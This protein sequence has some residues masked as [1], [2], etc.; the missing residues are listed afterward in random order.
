LVFVSLALLSYSHKAV[1]MAIQEK[2]L[3]ETLTGVA[4]NI[5]ESVRATVEETVRRELS[6]AISKIMLEGDFYRQINEEI[7]SGLR[8]IYKDIS[9]ASLPA[10]GRSPEQGEKTRELFAH[11]GEQLEEVMR[12]TLEATE[13]IMGTVEKLFAMHERAGELLTRLDGPDDERREHVR[14]L[15]EFHSEL[16]D[17][18]TY[19][20]TELSFQDLTGQRLKKVV[21]A[22]GDI[23]ETAFDLY[24]SSGLMIKGKEDEPEKDLD[25]IAEQT[26]LKV[27]EIK[28]SELRGPDRNTSQGDVD[29]LL[30]S[31][32][33]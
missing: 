1:L 21:T 13:N 25:S 23:Q 7:R 10:E 30:A 33:L 18:L 2:A 31:L 22:L 14:Q 8:G 28:N 12:S 26:R 29:D 11:A 9:A 32:G 27:A 24:V 15:G 6:A 20:L 4:R 5:A 19:I 17:S 16:Y 3:E